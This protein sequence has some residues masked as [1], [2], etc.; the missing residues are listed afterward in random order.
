MIL[1]YKEIELK[2]KR[3]GKGHESLIVED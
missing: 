3:L 2:I 1:K